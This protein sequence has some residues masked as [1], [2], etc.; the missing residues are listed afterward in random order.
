MNRSWHIPPAAF[1]WLPLVL[2]LGARCQRAGAAQPAPD[3]LWTA[4]PAHSGS[5]PPLRG[6]SRVFQ[7]NQGALK[8]LLGPVKIASSAN[9]SITLPLPDGSLA[10]FRFQEIE[11]LPP[12]LAQRFPQ[13]RTFAGQGIDDPAASVR[14][15]CTPAGV[16]AQ[17][18][19]PAGAVYINPLESGRSQLHASFGKRDYLRKTGDFACHTAAPA[20]SL[21][22]RTSPE[23]SE[24]TLRTYR[25]ACA[26]TAEFTA[27]HGGTVELALAAIAST[28]NRI[29]GIFESELAIRLT[30]IPDSD[31][32][33]YTNSLTDPYSNGDEVIMQF[34]NQTNLDLVIGDANYDIGHVFATAGGGQAGI[35][36]VCIPGAKGLGVTGVP[37]PD[38][39]PFWVDYVA[40]EIGHQFGANHTFNSTAAGC[41]GRDSDTAY[42][43]GSGSTIMAYAGICGG[44]NLQL[45]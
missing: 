3:E 25:F 35:G 20:L 16:H 5:Q 26:A 45:H 6:P 9:S 39:D 42:E 37:E 32:L 19:S 22:P 14:F 28:V 24:T 40:H 15:E 4:L 23:P 10:R 30:L 27:Y 41:I 12:S 29:N 2:L 34:Q 7:L 18:R 13:I 11:V 44:D 33:I 8:R 36:V 38:G 31:L 17:I 21:T 1:V 43:P